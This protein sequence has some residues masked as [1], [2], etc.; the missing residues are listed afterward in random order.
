MSVFHYLAHS[1]PIFGSN[2]ENKNDNAYLESITKQLFEQLDGLEAVP[3]VPI[4]K[5]APAAAVVAKKTD[6]H[7]DPDKRGG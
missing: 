6:E 4:Q 1:C 7:I 5:S 3:G 2:M